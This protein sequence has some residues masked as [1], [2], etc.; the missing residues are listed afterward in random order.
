MKPD[1]T[2]TTTY[3]QSA[4]DGYRG[5][6]LTTNITVHMLSEAEWLFGMT[7]EI[8]RL[9]ATVG[10]GL[11]GEPVEE[12][13]LLPDGLY[14]RTQDLE[15]TNMLGA[16]EQF[17]E[18]ITA[19]EL[20][21]AQ[22]GMEGLDLNE[23]HK[24]MY[25]DMDDDTGWERRISSNTPQPRANYEHP[26]NNPDRLGTQP[27]V[28]RGHSSGEDLG[29][30][31]PPSALA[32][33]NRPYQEVPKEFPRIPA[34]PKRAAQLARRPTNTLP[35]VGRGAIHS[36]ARGSTSRLEPVRRTEQIGNG[37]R[38]GIDIPNI[39]KLGFFQPLG[40]MTQDVMHCMQVAVA[41]QGFKYMGWDKLRDRIRAQVLRG[42]HYWLNSKVITETL[43]RVC[44][45]CLFCI[46]ESRTD[47]LPRSIEACDR[48]A[49]FRR[50]INDWR[51]GMHIDSSFNGLIK[52]THCA[53]CWMPTPLCPN[54]YASKGAMH[55]EP[56]TFRDIVLPLMY[57]I[58]T[59]NDTD[60]LK[61]AICHLLGFPESVARPLFDKW[62]KV[63]TLPGVAAE[64][65]GSEPRMLV[66]HQLL[67]GWLWSFAVQETKAGR[68]IA[69]L[70]DEI[71]VEPPSQV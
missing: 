60:A 58:D 20:E 57:Y 5:A 59:S 49:S 37:L 46:M 71:L 47:P 43:Y 22:E 32:E 23:R 1:G 35:N 9:A 36:H 19:V 63:L 69:G 31:E 45:R 50:K 40:P 11:E 27:D 28:P 33:R 53:G 24:G 34:V 14:G 26:D 52:I 4:E 16:D 29:K 21:E 61:M 38:T 41:Y 62:R 3:F 8:K 65:S 54:P 48:H 10:L 42:Q 2:T 70:R 18:E 30:G 64:G 12:E 7:D 68:R 17:G 15:A 6:A 66:M 25:E 67:A 51:K 44:H 55:E 13:S 56:C 39:N